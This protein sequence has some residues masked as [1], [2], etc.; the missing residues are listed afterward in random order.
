MNISIPVAAD[1]CGISP[2]AFRLY[3]HMMAMQADGRSF[4]PEIA[5]EVCRISM[6][7][8][9]SASFELVRQG[10]LRL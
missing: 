6:E 10:L 4:D 7:E 1:G 2:T 9:K 3:F 8:I 5:E